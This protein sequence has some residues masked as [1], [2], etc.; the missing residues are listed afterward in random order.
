MSLDL[1][2]GASTG[3]RSKLLVDTPFFLCFRFL[4][5]WPSLETRFDMAEK[6]GGEVYYVIKTPDL[7]VRQGLTIQERVLKNLR[8]VMICHIYLY[9]RNQQDDLCSGGASSKQ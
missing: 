6:G 5:N 2:G 1:L 8:R 3:S 7:F 9:S 4:W